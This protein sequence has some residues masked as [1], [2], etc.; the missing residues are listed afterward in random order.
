VNILGVN[1]GHMCSASLIQDGKIIAAVC[2]ERFTRNKNEQGFPKNAIEYC[3]KE[4]KL[5]RKDVDFIASTTLDL[6]VFV[7]ATK[8]Y[9]NFGLEGYL[10]ENREYWKPVLIEKKDIDYFSIFPKVP[11]ENYDFSFLEK[12]PDR[13]KWTELFRK[14]RKRNFVKEFG[15]SE[16][17]INFIDHHTGH[18]YYAY[19]MSPL[20]NNV[21]VVTADAW[22]DGCNCSISIGNDNKIEL[23]LKSPNN[24]LAR[25]Y[26]YITLLLGMKPNEHE[27]KV[28]GLAPYA[29]DYQIQKSYKIFKN[30]LYVDG[31]DFKFKEK[32]S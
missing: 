10:K 30:T 1:E 21:L 22:G 27:Y 6:E 25:W 32:P 20:R 11:N 8:R 19:F 12:E 15:I 3:L 16:N 26:K 23:K 14:E 17:K 9:V 4:G 13:K 31:L 29:T 28:M 2:E 5:E 7:E 24:F 18:A